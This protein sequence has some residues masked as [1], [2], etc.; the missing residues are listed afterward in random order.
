MRLVKY[1]QIPFKKLTDIQITE[2]ATTK[3]NGKDVQI[4]RFENPNSSHRYGL[5]IILPNGKNLSIMAPYESVNLLYEQLK[6]PND[7][8]HLINT[9]TITGDISQ[10]QAPILWLE[11]DG[12]QAIKP[13]PLS[14][15]DDPAE[16]LYNVF[17]MKKDNI[18]LSRQEKALLQAHKEYADTRPANPARERNDGRPV[19]MAA[20]HGGSLL[21]EVPGDTQDPL[22]SGMSSGAGGEADSS[23]N[24]R[25]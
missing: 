9:T 19:G 12:K 14:F 23:G 17:E 20:G 3:L 22:T 5:R 7:L 4:M 16:K 21:S 24:Y 15:T 1:K 13:P 6:N 11:H 18:P 25:S 8:R 10:E 2:Q